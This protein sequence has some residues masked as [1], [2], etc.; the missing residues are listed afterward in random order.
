MTVYTNHKELQQ[1][2]RELEKENALLKQEK[3]KYRHFLEN[4]NDIVYCLDLNAKV[5]YISPNVRKIAGYRPDEIIGRMYND[6]LHPDDMEKRGRYFR[7]V[8]SGENVVSEHK[9][10]TRNGGTARVMT[11]AGPMV[12][13]GIVV[14]VQGVL[15]DITRYKKKEERYRLIIENAGDLIFTVDKNGN[16]LYMS[17]NCKSILGY[18]PETFIGQ[19]FQSYVH[20]ED[21]DKIFQTMLDIFDGHRTSV[22]NYV[23]QKVVE[24]RAL[25]ENLHWRWLCAKNTILEENDGNYELAIIARDITE[26]KE[27]ESR[28]RESEETYRFMVEESNDIV[29]TF[30]LSKMR[31]TY[32]SKS[33]ERILGYS[34]ELASSYKLEDIFF[35]ETKKKI[36]STFAEL[37]NDRRHSPRILMEAEHRH[38]EGGSVWMEINAV[39]HRNSFGQPISFSGTSRDITRRKLTEKALRESEEKYRNLFENAPIGIFRTDDR[40]RGLLANSTMARILG[41]ATPE[42]AMVYYNDLSTQLYTDPQRRDRFLHLIREQGFVENFVFEAQTLDGHQLWLSMNARRVHPDS[43]GAFFI[44]GFTTDITSRKQAEEAKKRLEEQFHQAQKLESVGRLAGGVAH[45]LNNLLTPILGYS[46]LLLDGMNGN[47]ACRR[48]LE[49]IANAG[50]RARSLVGQLLA[51]SRKQALQ[52]QRIDINQ[53]LKN[54]E[55]LLRRAIREDIAIDWHPAPSLPK[56]QGDPG[57]LEQVVMNL[58]VNAQDAMPDGGRLIIET[59][60]V[61][62]DE[63]YA[64]KKKG[65]VPGPYVMITLSDTGSGMDADTMDHL[66]EPFFTTKEKD[67]GTGLGL[68]TS[69]GI[70][71]QHGGNIWAYSEPGLGTTFRVYLPMIDASSHERR[72]PSALSLKSEGGSETILVVEDDPQVNTLSAIILQKLGYTVLNA[73]SG[74]E[75]LAILQAHKGRVHLLLTDVIMPNMNGRKVFQQA[76]SIFPK[77]RVLYMS[78]YTDDVIAHHG[79]IDPTVDFIQKPF[80]AKAL[81]AKVREVLDQ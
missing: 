67:K 56:V 18:P 29:W 4:L 62:L 66:F 1:R 53:L 57:Q 39:L 34:P 54:F 5:T 37:A 16:F 65:V 7:K 45:D 33:V 59:S 55:N 52:F 23:N 24:F 41:F 6:F 44:E 11:N 72:S 81:T 50:T 43:R 36:F 46:E 61:E 51:F 71:K 26:Q 22:K 3:N 19:N 28:L 9:L 70:V 75:A 58:A 25:T 17:P 10:A 68:A 8:L 40:G 15:V 64:G 76:A 77:L 60:R 79:I 30:D 42:A 80:T 73:E 14:G 13:D 31:Y 38:R 78:G 63:T 12:E 69:Y 47:D 74:Q 21:V 32:C 35:P 2:V 27:I 20:P 48:P 49:E